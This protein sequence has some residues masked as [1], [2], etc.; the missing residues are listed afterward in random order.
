MCKQYWPDSVKGSQAWKVFDKRKQEEL[1][2]VANSK[3]ECVPWG[4]RSIK[5][6]AEDV[7]CVGDILFK[8]RSVSGPDWCNIH[9]PQTPFGFMAWE[10]IAGSPVSEKEQKV[11]PGKQSNSINDK[12]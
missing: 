8:C 10:M 1:P 2:P 5:W 4:D 6:K 12:P 3:V 11:Q 7:A 9:D